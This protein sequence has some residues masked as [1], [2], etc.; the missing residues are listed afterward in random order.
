MMSPCQKCPVREI[1]IKPC[2]LVED[3]IEKDIDIELRSFFREEIPFSKT[4]KAKK[5]KE[6][7]REKEINADDFIKIDW[8]EISNGCSNET[9]SNFDPDKTK[10]INECIKYAVPNIKIRRRYR[11]YLNCEKMTSIAKRAGVAKQTIK[12]QFTGITRK[13]FKMYEKRYNETVPNNPFKF[14]K[15]GGACIMEFK[16]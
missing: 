12:K 10:K 1:C 16:K 13:I 9:D 11:A 2:I 5:V 6:Q 4:K 7:D 3:L 8:K 15:A 14:K